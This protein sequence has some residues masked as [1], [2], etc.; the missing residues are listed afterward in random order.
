MASNSTTRVGGIPY[1][2][3][4]GGVSMVTV[5]QFEKVRGFTNKFW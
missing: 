5:E 1:K 4:F 3:Y 2:N